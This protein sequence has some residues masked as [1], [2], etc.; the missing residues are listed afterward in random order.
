[1]TSLAASGSPDVL[2]CAPHSEGK[3]YASSQLLGADRHTSTS[4]VM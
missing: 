3:L 4:K 1:M 2:D